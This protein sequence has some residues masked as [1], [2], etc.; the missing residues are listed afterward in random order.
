MPD[1]T[2]VKQ[3]PR[4][5]PEAE[6]AIARN[7]VF[8]VV[9]GLGER[10]KKQWRRLWNRI[11]DLEPGEMIEISTTQ[12]RLGWYHRKHFGLMQAL[13]ESQER[14]DDFD[15]FIIW[16]KVGA[17][18]VL[19]MPGSKGGVFPVPK[20]I[21]YS[22]MEQGEFEEHHRKVVDFLRTEHAAR[23]L[24]KHLKPTARIE[25]I[26]SILGEFRE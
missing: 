16:I 18:H 2:L 5:V 8:G 10:G 19:W 3:D 20:S 4:E 11:M 12:S 15:Q 13:F 21:S 14:F 23:T 1:F 24:W 7:F 9:D 22:K 6:R 25:M 17:G 26:E